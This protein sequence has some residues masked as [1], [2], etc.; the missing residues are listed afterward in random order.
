MVFVGFSSFGSTT[1]AWRLSRGFIFFNG[2]GFAFDGVNVSQPAA[3]EEFFNP[4]TGNEKMASGAANAEFL[5]KF[6][7]GGLGKTQ[8]M[9]KFPI[10]EAVALAGHMSAV[11]DD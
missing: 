6:A 7:G 9:A 5:A 1:T 2:G 10:V 4:G 11:G 3:A 8:E